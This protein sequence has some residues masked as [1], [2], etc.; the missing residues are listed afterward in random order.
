LLRFTETNDS[1]SD[2][3]GYKKFRNISVLFI[4]WEV[5]PVSPDFGGDLE[6]EI[7]AMVTLHTL[8][9]CSRQ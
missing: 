7:I 3:P 9:E 6:E 2:K 8:P 1:K 5:R 4:K